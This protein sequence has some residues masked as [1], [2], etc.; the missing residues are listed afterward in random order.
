MKSATKRSKVR[1]HDELTT[2]SVSPAFRDMITDLA[3]SRR[4]SVREYCDTRATEALGPDYAVIL[5]AKL[6][7]VGG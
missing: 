2:L 5:K 1:K 3:K 6:A 7:K 4:V